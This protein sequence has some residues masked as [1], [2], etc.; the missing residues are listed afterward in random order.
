MAKISFFQ[1]QKDLLKS[2]QDNDDESLRDE[3]IN[4]IQKRIMEFFNMRNIHFLF[5]SGT[6]CNAIPNMGGLFLEVKMVI[7]SSTIKEY[8]RKE[9]YELINR[10]E[11]KENLEEILGILYSQSVYLANY[12]TYSYKLDVCESLIDIIE[13]T[14]FSKIN[15]DFKSTE[16]N[17]VLETYKLF[18]SK[19]AL[20]NKDLS[21]LNIFTTNNDLLMKQP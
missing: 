20:R 10:I 8:T 7:D 3:Q 6:S 17:G 9:F 15:I 12:E 11:N 2:M 21:R 13:K 1:G 5:G 18:Y 4:E 14:I 16:A 19:L